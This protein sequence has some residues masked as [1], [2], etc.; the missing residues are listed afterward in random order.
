MALA[1]LRRLIAAPKYS[2][3]P[4]YSPEESREHDNNAQRLSSPTAYLDGLRG[5]AAFFVFVHHFS[6]DPFPWLLFGWG[7]KRDDVVQHYI[8][9]LPIV[10][11]VHSGGS[12]VAIFFVI[13]GFALSYSPLK[14]I[15][16]RDL[17]AVGQGLASSVFRRIFRLYLPAVATSF[18]M[19]LA[20][21][22]KVAPF[23]ARRPRADN[24]VLEFVAWLHELWLLINPFD[25]RFRL[26]RYDDNL[27]TLNAEFRGSMALYLT[28]LGVA[29]FQ[30]RTRLVIEAIVSVWLFSYGLWDVCLFTAGM[31]LAELHLERDAPEAQS[32]PA[33]TP[34]TPA[35]T[36]TGLRRILLFATFV[37]SLHLT[38]AP[39][40]G[41]KEA[42]GYAW[43]YTLTPPSWDVRGV[44]NRFLPTLGAPLLVLCVDR[45]MRLRSL[46]CTPLAAWLGRISFG[47]YLVHGPVRYTWYHPLLRSM[48]DVM[49]FNVTPAEQDLEIKYGWLKA[50]MTM[51]T[52]KATVKDELANSALSDV[53]FVIAVFATWALVL[54]VTLA[55]AD[56]FSRTVDDGS[57][58][59]AKKIEK[60]LLGDDDASWRPSRA[61]QRQSHREGSYSHAGGR[62]SPRC[63]SPRSVQSPL[64]AQSPR[65]S[66]SRS[67]EWADREEMREKLH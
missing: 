65:L 28:I 51:T 45:S 61:S 9:Q 22:M 40:E 31:M 12:M 57:V 46:F 59:L 30:Y 8:L 43:P 27:W 1:W 17:G 29:R 26:P 44:G 3:L 54:P 7:S 56:A 42:T 64:L 2:R 55:I 6:K 13:S 66:R 11:L 32:L 25:L 58:A 49:G 19:M 34:N 63:R 38:S 41:Y 36:R 4:M 14:N 47:L 10:R 15:R 67:T 23:P 33:H 37:L 48:I 35:S 52:D 18:V 53:R 24:I 5:L 21:Q 50:I 39:L 60:K 16:S 20:V 62:A